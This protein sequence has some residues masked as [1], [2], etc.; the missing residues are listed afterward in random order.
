MGSGA[1]VDGQ[2]KVPT[3]QA[4]SC[5]THLYWRIGQ[6]HLPPIMGMHTHG[7]KGT[8]NR[9]PPNTLQALMDQLRQVPK[10]QP[11]KFTSL[12]WLYC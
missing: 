9:R 6:V 11:K 10:A 7:N 12:R 4:R 3:W 8:S 5:P 1:S 2:G